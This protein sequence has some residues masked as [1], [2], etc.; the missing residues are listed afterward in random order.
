MR[1]PL[2]T[3]TA[4]S[5]IKRPGGAAPLGIVA[6]I[7]SKRVRQSLKTRN[8]REAEESKAQLEARL[9]GASV[10][11][12]QHVALFED[13]ALS[14]LEDGHDPRFVAPLL[15]HFRGTALRQ[16]TPK[17]I[18]DAAKKIYAGCKGATMN[19]QGIAPARA[20]INHAAEQGLCQAIR[21]KQFPTEPPKRQAVGI[22]WIQSFR[23][24]AIEHGNRR[25]AALVWFLF[26]TGARISEAT[27]LR[28]G[29][30]DHINCRANLGKTKNGD[31][32]TAAISQPLR[33]ELANLAS[34]NGKVFGFKNRSGVY[35][36]WR[37]NCGRAEIAYVPPHQ[38]GRHSLA[39]ALNAEGWSA[40]DIA[41]AGRWKS[42]RLVQ[43]TY[44]HSEDKGAVAARQIG[45]KLAKLK[46]AK[47]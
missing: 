42:V 24:T 19:R 11:G 5:W 21:V 38:A 2:S 9:W 17:N 22:E 47:R 28:D 46:S 20:I 33:D 39:T 25:L 8:K 12:I 37:T 40:N 10:Y 3:I 14:Y 29:D 26:E 45:K 34:R 32:Q 43:D 18:R 36:P 23:E 4:N 7:G 16:I 1:D 27:G 44:I 30:I 13:A 41:K 15:R 6:P 35:G 31:Y